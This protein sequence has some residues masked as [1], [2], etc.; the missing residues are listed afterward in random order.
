MIRG[1][2]LYRGMFRGMS[3]KSYKAAV[4]SYLF[5]ETFEAAGY[6][7]AG[8][9]ETLGTNG[10][11]NEDDTTAPVLEGSQQLK[12]YGSSEGA[13][14]SYTISPTF[15]ASGTIYVRFRF[16][17]KDDRPSTNNIFYLYTGI[18]AKQWINFI[19][20]GELA[21]TTGPK[22]AT[23]TAKILVNTSYYIW[24]K[25]IKGTGANQIGSVAFST[26]TTEPTSDDG[27][28]GWAQLTDGARTDNIDT[29]RLSYKGYYNAYFD[30]ILVSASPIT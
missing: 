20:T 4:G 29:L 30:E 22:T 6:D 9:A 17:I 21:V 26:T 10:I 11:V 13:E 23:T 14:V 24:V 16:R 2:G 3:P 8:W 5:Q 19:S 7:N 1:R 28:N 27:T 18:G 12:I 15:T 25:Y